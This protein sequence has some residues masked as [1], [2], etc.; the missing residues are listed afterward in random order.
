MRGG[1]RC[2][3]GEDY[4]SQRALQPVEEHRPPAGG[5]DVGGAAL[6]GGGT[7]LG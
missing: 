5:R 1:R 4:D 3:A 7:C 6:G 2:A